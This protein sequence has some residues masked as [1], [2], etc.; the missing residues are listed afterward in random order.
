MH[1]DGQVITIA[2]NPDQSKIV[3]EED[4]PEFTY[5]FWR[6]SRQC[7]SLRGRLERVA[8]EEVGSYPILLGSLTAGPKNSIRYIRLISGSGR[9]VR[10]TSMSPLSRIAKRKAI[11]IPLSSLLSLPPARARSSPVTWN[12]IPAKHPAPTGSTAGWCARRIM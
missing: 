11:P 2:A 7:D 3:G 8:G 1:V 5:T 6:H 4:P 12:V 9:K 10:I